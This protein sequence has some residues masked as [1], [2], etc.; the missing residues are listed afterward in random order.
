MGD[1]GSLFIELVMA[2]IMLTTS[3]L[4]VSALA[5]A[6]AQTAPEEPVVDVA[7]L[8]PEAPEPAPS[9]LPTKSPS[10][11]GIPFASLTLRPSVV[12][13]MIRGNLFP[14]LDAGL[15][16]RRGDTYLQIEPRLGVE[17][18]FSR[19][20]SLRAEYA[21]GFRTMSDITEVIRPNH[22]G[23]AAIELPLGGGVTLRAGDEWSRGVLDTSEADP[24]LEY[25][26]ELGRYTHNLFDVNGRVERRD[27]DADAGLT[28]NRV[29][30]TP[31]SGFFSHR[32]RSFYAGAGRN[33]GATLHL[34]LGYANERVPRLAERPEA[35]TRSHLYSVTL[36]GA[37]APLTDGQIMVG[38]RDHE[39]PTAGIGG[40]HFGGLVVAGRIEKEFTRSSRL[41]LWGSR[42][43]RL[44]LLRRS[45]LHS[46][47]K[48]LPEIA[49]P[50]LSA[51]EQN[52]FY[53]A[54]AFAAEIELSLPLLCIARGGVAWQGN[55]YH[56]VASEIGANRMDA[57]FGWSVGLGRPLAR[58]AWIRA[59]F[60]HDRRNSNLDRL[61]VESEALLFQLGI[62]F[63]GGRVR[64][65][66]FGSERR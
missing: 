60:R 11:D 61:D 56:T 38:Y 66:F 47:T 9:P 12:V 31:G 2:T 20:G 33:I 44:D 55:D 23:F 24:G 28:L 37:L 36:D 32:S 59:D 63:E 21:P 53:V 45:G 13:T 16:V 18:S 25:F 6:A 15:P 35:E 10:P 40:R 1:G 51:F 30:L 65:A 52:A 50:T 48:G 14:N 27:F 34:R 29:A 57:L 42:D 43:T 49:L 46:T 39:A 3:L 58:R 4:L 62:G 26:F 19:G 7:S 64:P 41:S 17:H 22:R 5:A 54:Q 8:F